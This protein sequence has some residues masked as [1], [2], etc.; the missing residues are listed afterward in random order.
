VTRRPIARL[1]SALALLALVVSATPPAGT[2]AAGPP[3]REVTPVSPDA[4]VASAIAPAQ[5]VPV[6]VPA[7]LAPPTLGPAQVAPAFDPA[8]AADL[9]AV[10]LRNVHQGYPGLSAAAIMPDGATWQAAAG[11]ADR[12]TGTR[13][14]WNTLF[15]VY[16]ISKTFVATIVLELAHEGVLSLDDT[17][18]RWLPGLVGD[19]RFS[20]DKV[21]I[22]ELLSHT[23]GIGEYLG[24]PMLVRAY[25]K[26]RRTWTPDRLLGY[27]GKPEFAPGT[28]WAYSNTNYLLLGMIIQKA[29]GTTVASQLIRRITRP[30]GLTRTFLQAQQR[31]TGPLAHGYSKDVMGAT[32][33]QPMDPWDGSGFTPS[34]SIASA[35]W[36]VG[37]IVSTPLQLARWA[38]ALYGGRVLD[39]ASLAQMLDFAPALATPAKGRY[40][41]G[42][43]WKTV[44][45]ELTV[46]HN[47]GYL[48]FQG[49]MWY[50]TV[51]HVTIVVLSNTDTRPV[52]S[53]F[54]SLAAVI[55]DHVGA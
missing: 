11:Y 50:L 29:T 39:P 51:H 15:D 38:R 46:G 3:S 25:A 18:A 12:A 16:S 24:N 43:E 8:L 37:G 52:T 1:A 54:D 20:A 19:P 41:L 26:F 31:P 7:Q 42:T 34:L 40:G 36:T 30:L 6:L 53:V 47:G 2:L 23:S 32:W 33:A 21:T 35:C 5:A 22:R 4:V 55:L 44:R 27:V 14:T 49:A 45:G 28:D 9:N 13:V 17:L 10:L 48:G